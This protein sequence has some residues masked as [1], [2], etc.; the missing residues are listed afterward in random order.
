MFR[1]LLTFILIL[2]PFTTFAAPLIP[3]GIVTSPFGE[4]NHFGH[5]HAGIDIALGS[6]TPILAPANGVVSHGT[7]SGYIYWVQI[8]TDDGL[9]YFVGDCREETLSFPTGYVNEGTIIGLT[10][11]D[12]YNGPLGISTGPH[13]HIEVFNQ[14]GYVVGSQVNPYLY[15]TSLGVDLS[16]NLF[17]PGDGQTGI[18]NGSAIGSD[19]VELPWGV[20]SMYELGNNINNDIEKFSTAAGDALDGLDNFVLYL[21]WVL[22]IID[23]TLPILLSGMTIS[24]EMLISKLF[25]Y[26]L[27]M[28]IIVNWQLLINDFFLSMVSSI[29]GTYTNDPLTVSANVTQPQ[30][31]IKKCVYMLTPALNKISSYKSYDFLL[32]LHYIVPIFIFTWFTIIVYFLLAFKIALTYIE[33]YVTALFNIVTLPFAQWKYMKFMPEGTIGHL[34]NVTLELIATSVMVFL[35]VSVIEDATPGKIFSMVDQYGHV[36][37]IDGWSLAQYIRL[38]LTLI[39]LAVLTGTIPTRIAKILGGQFE[40]S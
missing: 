20:E 39:A 34:L 1:I 9:T 14:T 22:A 32:N 4:T 40:M 13:A 21:L 36:S 18:P 11:G 28:V 17:P 19:N 31:I 5:V 30:L 24:K 35:T 23:L 38:C 33:F 6:G 3:G 26:G 27:L 29:A 8:D 2:M 10:G 37:Y 7:G 12:A 25:K 16:G 15:L